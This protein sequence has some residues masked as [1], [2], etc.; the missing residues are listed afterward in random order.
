[1]CSDWLPGTATRAT[2]PGVAAT[3]LAPPAVD[4]R[5]AWEAARA[6]LSAA[7]KAVEQAF[8]RQVSAEVRDLRRDLLRLDRRLG[9]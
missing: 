1:M 6:Q 9:G 4:R 5:R 3:Q 8:G 7:V 2:V